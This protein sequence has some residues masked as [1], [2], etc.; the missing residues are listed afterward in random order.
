MA[1]TVAGAGEGE[2]PSLPSSSTEQR[3]AI[4]SLLFSSM[5]QGHPSIWGF[6]SVR[7]GQAHREAEHRHLCCP[8]AEM[9]ADQRNPGVLHTGMVLAGWVL[10]L[11]SRELPAA[12]RLQ[13]FNWLSAWGGSGVEMTAET[14]E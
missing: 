14:E 11:Q 5:Q 8:P 2:H 3:P 13:V 7:Q 1:C 4:S 12:A 10:L 6:A 9:G